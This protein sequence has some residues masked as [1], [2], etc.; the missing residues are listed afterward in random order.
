MWPGRVL[1]Q[2]GTLWPA[3]L[4]QFRIEADQVIFFF[5]FV[6]FLIFIYFCFLGPYPTAYGGSRP[7]EE[8][9]L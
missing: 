8:S 9:E 2:G 1:R 5:V 4:R 6:F 3:Q 7:G